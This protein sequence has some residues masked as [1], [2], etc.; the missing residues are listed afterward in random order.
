[1]NNPSML[2]CGHILEGRY[3][4]QSVIGRGGMSTVFLAIDNRLGK[5]RA[6]KEICRTDCENAQLLQ[7]ISMTEAEML[8]K[9]DHPNLPQI[10]DIISEGQSMILI[11]DYIPGRNLQDL[12]DE[13]MFFDEEKVVTWGIQLTDLLGYLHN[14]K[15]PVIYRDMKPSNIMIRDDGTPVLIDFGTAREYLPEDNGDTVCLGTRGYAAPEQYNGRGQ[16]DARTDIYG[17]GVTLY[18]L[19][20]GRTLSDPPYRILPVRRIRPCLSQGIE[21]I[22]SRCTEPDP[23]ERYAD[24]EELKNTLIHLN[25]NS[26]E[27]R[28][29]EW[30]KIVIA[31]CV[32]GMS[33][34]FMLLFFCFG[35]QE[36]KN[37]SKLVAFYLQ[38][39]RSDI[40]DK[41]K[42]INFEK[43]LDTDPGSRYIYRSI[44]DQYVDRAGFSSGDAAGVISLVNRVTGKGP[45][46]EI[47]KKEDTA[48]YGDF[49]YAF[50]IAC[51]YHIRGKAGKEIAL[52]WFEETQN[53][54]DRNFSGKKKKRA[55]LYRRI[56]WYYKR[57]PDSEVE[58]ERG[59]Y[60][61]WY[62]DFYNALCLLNRVKIREDDSDE[63]I[64]TGYLISKE[65]AIELVQY[66][67]RFVQN[68]ISTE[69]LQKEIGRIYAKDRKEEGTR[70]EKA[71]K[72]EHSKE[73]KSRMDIFKER[74]TVEEVRELQ[75][76]L[77]DAE[78]KVLLLE[79]RD[80]LKG[81]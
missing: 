35:L 17:L 19:L 64:E 46:L 72:K 75:E 4:I 11:M 50:G 6:I 13:R 10:V 66:G 65:V 68:G 52:T 74:K 36:E 12:L 33:F 62:K 70:R 49:C 32:L 26:L 42:Y 51:F 76:L 71:E 38:N 9:L 27:F 81:G 56:C 5:K 59:N 67:E 61:K 80:S 41:E 69:D 57:F 24:C 1:M 40:D 60:G 44:L 20:T 30:R 54:E 37:R 15:P 48:G 8:K 18:Q 23:R 7:N 14:Q 45:C 53:L 25:E 16:T 39:A 31:G 47:L 79:N 58:G 77:E 22:I 55:A 34:L 21:A 43:A 73:E 78:R 29:E 3:E 2:R 28:R 63:E